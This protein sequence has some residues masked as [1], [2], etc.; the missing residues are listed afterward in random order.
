MG[1]NRASPDVR[2]PPGLAVTVLLPERVVT[3]TAYNTAMRLVSSGLS[4]RILLALSQGIPLTLS[5]LARALESGP[6]TV[7]RALGILIEDGLVKVKSKAYQLTE[8]AAVPHLL[9]L[10]SVMAPFDERLRIAARVNPA[11][12]FVARREGELVIVFAATSDAL[13]ESKAAR[14]VTALCA[15]AGLRP[16][17]LYHDDVRKELLADPGLR[18]R[19]ASAA[20]LY[21]DLDRS[22][23]DRSRHRMGGD[24]SLGCPHESLRLPSRRFLQRLAKKH[25]LASLKL[26]GSA[27]RSDFRPDSDVDVL[28]RYRSNVKP[29]LASLREL[30]HGLERAI[31]RDV[32]LL[33]DEALLTEL[34]SRVNAEAVPLL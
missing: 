3:L 34:R 4:L 13:D 2:K 14:A 21:G 32:D 30:E 17:Y 7:Q 19:M 31:G 24:V 20:V 11:I 12:E 28:V 29:S 9:G 8:N 16:R 27:T 23:P 22:F 6:S 1:G 33:R 25:Q 18:Q 26:F 15:E 10:A 5:G